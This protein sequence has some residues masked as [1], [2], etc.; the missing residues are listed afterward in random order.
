MNN[1]IIFS[2]LFLS[3]S[4]LLAACG[5]GEDVG[6]DDSKTV[7]ETKQSNDEENTASDNSKNNEDENASEDNGSTESDSTSEGEATS[8]EAS[9]DEEKNTNL[10]ES[11]DLTKENFTEN[12]VSINY[13]QITGLTDID[14]EKTLNDLLNKE[15][16]KVLNFYEE[17][18]GL[19]LEI[20]YAISFQNPYFLSVQYAGSGYVDG[21]AHPNNLFYTTNVDVENGNRIRLSDV[22]VID[23]S[24]LSL[25]QSDAFK[26]VN[27]DQ[28]EFA[29]ELKANVTVDQLQNADNL[30]GIGTEQHSET[31]TYFT[32]SGLG[33][34]IGTSHAAGGHAAFEMMYVDSPEEM[35]DGDKIWDLLKV[36]Q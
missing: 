16:H 29:N 8:E 3:L 36:Y 20:D 31:F 35:W 14:K 15:A 17:S 28:E 22:V 25:F 7:D 23:E 32:E 4:L 5:Q 9:S 24:F 27:P 30:D 11:Y 1:K 13:P 21:A 6:K 10:N 34:S 19:D 12:G 26:V 2:A 18:N 33:I